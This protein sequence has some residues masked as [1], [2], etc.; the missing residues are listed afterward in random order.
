MIQWLNVGC[1]L[2][3]CPF[4]EFSLSCD[5]QSGCVYY[6]LIFVTTDSHFQYT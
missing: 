5:R 4:G 1:V 3:T 2:I 6:M